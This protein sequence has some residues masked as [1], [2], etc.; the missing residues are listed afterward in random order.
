MPSFDSGILY[1]IWLDN[2]VVNGTAYVET[3]TGTRNYTFTA[4]MWNDY[5]QTGNV[6]INIQVSPSC[7]DADGCGSP[8]MIYTGTTL[9][10]AQ[11]NCPL[12][13]TW[14]NHRFLKIQSSERPTLT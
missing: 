7:E 3:I 1:Q 13:G 2:S 5:N 9:S 14:Y 8:L 11:A 12:T 4:W 6:T 10:E